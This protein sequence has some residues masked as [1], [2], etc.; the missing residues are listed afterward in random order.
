MA[1]ES[2]SAALCATKQRA[3]SLHYPQ[4]QKGETVDINKLMAISLGANGR[5]SLGL[6]AKVVSFIIRHSVIL[7]SKQ[8]YRI[9][10]FMCWKRAG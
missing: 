1:G 3:M 6:W 5:V 9:V 2:L 8:N 7:Y 10:M 4:P